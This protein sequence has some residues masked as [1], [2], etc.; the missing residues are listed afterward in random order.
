MTA[1]LGL[2]WAQASNGVI[3]RD[4][5]MPWHVPEDMARF[6]SL[7]VGHPVIMGRR[8]WDSIAPKY[9]PLVD[10]RN[11]V[12]SRQPDFAADGAV[13]VDSV[14]AAL[15]EV[16]GET[17]WVMGGGQLYAATLP[18]ATRLEV[19]E[20]GADV[21]GDTYAP[22]IDASWTLASLD[23]DSGWHTSRTGLTY[24]FATYTRP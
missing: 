12:V 3:G 8:T 6:K 17:A 19:T 9:R 20:I 11:I 21:D 10:R 24:R 23:P 4:G 18:V 5:V 14:E 15:A 13:V 16:S 7:T 1:S 2:I 22:A